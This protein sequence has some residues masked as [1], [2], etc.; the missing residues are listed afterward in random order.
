M[1]SALSDSNDVDPTRGQSLL[2][3]ISDAIGTCPI[4]CAYY[5]L[6]YQSSADSYTS[7]I[8]LT[9]Q[10]TRATFVSKTLCG[11]NPVGLNTVGS[12]RNGDGWFGDDRKP[13]QWFKCFL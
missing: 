12:F 1:S 6:K 7:Y 9:A 4:Q 13:V 11:V 10:S 5:N 3:A 2:P 8:F